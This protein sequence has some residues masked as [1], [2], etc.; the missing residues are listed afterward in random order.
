MAV[1]PPGTPDGGNGCGGVVGGPGGPGQV[2]P[3]HVET[4][5]PALLDP[6][7][8]EHL[9]PVRPALDRAGP[10]RQPAVNHR[11]PAY[12][13]A[14]L[15]V[16]RADA[17]VIFTAAAQASAAADFVQNFSRPGAAGGADPARA[18]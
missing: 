8:L 3:K 5:P 7:D 13:G 10:Q 18:A 12:L 4:E 16:L 14:W 2:S 11:Q 15:R 9:D 1:L 6:Q 17:R